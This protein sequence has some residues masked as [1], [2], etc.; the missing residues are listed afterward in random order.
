MTLFSWFIEFKVYARST[1]VANF[2][3]PF[4]IYLLSYLVFIKKFVH[5]RDF[6]SMFGP[7][8]IVY[9]KKYMAKV[10]FV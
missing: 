3:Q 2:C 9:L 1:K 5:S 10:L 7:F 4:V 6:D 8:I